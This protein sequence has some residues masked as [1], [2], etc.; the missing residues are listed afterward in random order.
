[1]SNIYNLK[2]SEKREYF[3]KD[4]LDK[5]IILVAEHIIFT[6]DSYRK[7]AKKF[8]ISAPTVLSY[9]RKYKK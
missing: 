9:C 6:G 5:K 3:L 4:E 1:M 7:T 2:D 8:N